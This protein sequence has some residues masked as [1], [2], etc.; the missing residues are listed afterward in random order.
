MAQLQSLGVQTHSFNV[1]LAEQAGLAESIILQHFYFWHRANTDNPDMTKDGRVWFFRS[2]KSIC[3]DFGYL[4]PSKVKTAIE[5]LVSEGWILKGDYNTDRMKRVAWYSLTDYTLSLFTGTPIGENRQCNSDFFV[6]TSENGDTIGENDT[7]IGDFSQC[8]DNNNE[9]IINSFTDIKEKKRK[10][11]KKEKDDFFEECWKA[12]HRKGSKKSATSQWK[13]L[14]AEDKDKVGNHIPHY[15]GSRELSYQK[16]F[17]RYLRD[18]IFD[19]PVYHNNNLVYDPESSSNTEYHPY[20]NNSI[21]WNDKM[22]MYVIVGDIRGEI[23]D[24]YTNESRPN[25]AKIFNQGRCYIWNSGNAK[26]EVV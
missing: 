17:E 24:G 23:I 5:K 7:T 25:G 21:I 14:S 15:V 3:D 19:T 26:W 16:D 13:K 6:K 20:G 4:T 11:I 10:N 22:Q 9:D 18:R 1:S 8:K 12:Y 2:V